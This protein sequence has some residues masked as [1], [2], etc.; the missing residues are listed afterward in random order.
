MTVETNELNPYND[1]S[2][3]LDVWYNMGWYFN[4]S[5]EAASVV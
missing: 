2:G 4:P 3:T 5:C 1:L